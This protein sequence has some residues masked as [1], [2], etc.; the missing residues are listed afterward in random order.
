MRS[1]LR[2][3]YDWPPGN[4]PGGLFR[5]WRACPGRKCCIEIIIPQSSPSRR[6]SDEPRLLLRLCLVERLGQQ[7]LPVGGELGGR[8]HLGGGSVRGG[9]GDH[10]IPVEVDIHLLA[11]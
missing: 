2:A 8:F 6:R 9:G 10:V 11:G 3:C 1:L 4:S 7:R 5:A